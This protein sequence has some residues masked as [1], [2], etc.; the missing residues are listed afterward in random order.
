MHG[1][2]QGGEDGGAALLHVAQVVEERGYAVA[3]AL[4]LGA[5]AE[6]A[7]PERRP[8]RSSAAAHV[9]DLLDGA[10]DTGLLAC[11]IRMAWVPICEKSSW[12][13]AHWSADPARSFSASTNLFP[14]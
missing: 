9:L 4:G 1:Q 2:S 8:G 6:E 10:V 5:A 11:I 13:T 12:V 3:A 7:G 14:A